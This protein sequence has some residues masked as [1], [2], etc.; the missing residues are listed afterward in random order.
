MEMF[1]ACARITKERP[2][3]FGHEQLERLGLRGYRVRNVGSVIV[4]QYR[5]RNCSTQWQRGDNVEKYR[6]VWRPA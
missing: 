5:C 3:Q 4:E 2:E 1:A 6:P